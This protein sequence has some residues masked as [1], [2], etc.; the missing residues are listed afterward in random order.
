MSDKTSKIDI[1][2]ESHIPSDL[3]TPTL[4]SNY[5]MDGYE[6]MEYGRGVIEGVLD[7]DLTPAPALPTGLSR[8]A[9]AEMDLA[10][11][12]EESV[13]DLSWLDGAQFEDPGR[14]P[15]TPQSVPELEDA[16]GK[17]TDGIQVFAQDLERVRYESSLEEA[18]AKKSASARQLKKVATHAMR[19]SV[20]GHAIE[21]VVK[22][23]ME[24]VGES[25]SSLAPIMRRVQGEHGLH[26]KVYVRASA[27]PGWGTGKW[28]PEV[29]KHASKA[30]YIVVSPEDLQNSVWIKEGRCQY[31]SKIAVTSVPWDEA[32]E[33]YAP[34]LRSAGIPV[35]RTGSPDRDLQAAFLAKPVAVSPDTE[36][37]PVHVT[38]D[39]RVSLQEARQAFD[40]YKPT[41]KVYDPSQAREK[42]LNAA[43]ERTVLR[44]VKGGLLPDSEAKTLLASGA[45][46]E[47][48]VKSAAMIAS[49]V[50]SGVYLGQG[51]TLEAT[52]ALRVARS[53]RRRNESIAQIERVAKFGKEEARRFV[54]SLRKKSL[55]TEAQA[56]DLL[57]AELSPREV[58]KNATYLAYTPKKSDYRG[59][60]KA[61]DASLRVW[62][63]SVA[64]KAAEVAGSQETLD[65]AAEKR[66]FSTTFAGRDD[67]RITKLAAKISNEVERGVRGK[68]LRKYIAKVVPV[69]DAPKVL[70]K[71]PGIGKA[72][73]ES[74]P[75]TKSYDQTQYTRLAS[76][77]RAKTVLAGQV[78]AASAWLRRTISEGWAGPDLDSL[79]D[80]RFSDAVQKASS[81]NFS[82]I[83]EAHEGL[84]GFVYVDA[85]A[86]ASEAGSAGCEKAASKHRT[87][88]IPSVRAMSRCATCTLARSLE[89]GTRKCGAYGKLL[90]S[91][92][93]FEGGDFSGIR[94]A[95]IQ[96]AGMTDAET[97][98]SF[99]APTYNPG[100]FGLR[101][102]NL[103]GVE[104]QDLP[105]NEKIAVLFEGWRID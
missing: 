49:R 68:V 6:D 13:T 8:G 21:T 84:S 104:L 3:L 63:S 38:P 24:S 95:N 42:A 26:G 39:Q 55:L 92:E 53:T 105:E 100:E 43:A 87:N 59:Q 17:G 16:W 29:K 33:H 71:L 23:A 73:E 64:R 54:A 44:M 47:E 61:Q 57:G 102:S 25:M 19:R 77:R 14:L 97:T 11:L 81:E 65:H 50:K 4:G 62:E 10:P 5:G 89:D 51:G 27:Y 34:R 85:E 98:A 9:S 30:R 46:P 83:R 37:R 2:G 58:A 90:A 12:F 93:D 66:K 101:N 70:R 103:E 69:V 75:S 48:I 18:P 88:Q 7:P 52:Q 31:T 82:Q 76:E 79:V 35:E 67:A 56:S 20:R 74:A 91:A 40:S 60:N 72:L 15:E 1:L 41:R 28:A 80:K 22:E 32:W 78:R 45:T 86:Y 94:E 99:F 36:S 96:A